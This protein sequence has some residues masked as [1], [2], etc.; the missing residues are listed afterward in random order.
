MYLSIPMLSLTSVI[1]PWRMFV[2]VLCVC[3]SVRL[4]VTMLVAIYIPYLYVES[5]VPLGFS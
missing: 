4:S 5:K 1:N 2:V 3:L